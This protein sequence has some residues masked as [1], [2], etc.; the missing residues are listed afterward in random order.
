MPPSVGCAPSSKSGTERPDPLYG[1]GAIVDVAKVFPMP[2]AG[3]KWN[4]NEITA[5]GA[6]VTVVFNG[7]K[8]VDNQDTRFAEGPFAQRP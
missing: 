2:K 3:G 7:V 6:Q 4:T 1:T 5:K 8:T